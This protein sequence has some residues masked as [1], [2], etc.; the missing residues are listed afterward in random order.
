M[1][2]AEILDVE[3]LL[4]L[5]PVDLLGAADDGDEV[6]DPERATRYFP[7]P[8]TLFDDSMTLFNSHDLQ[9]YMVPKRT[10]DSQK[11][12][13]KIFI[14]KKQNNQTHMYKNVKTKGGIEHQSVFRPGYLLVNN[15]IGSCQGTCE[16]M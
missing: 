12:L 8:P 5:F 7:N 16:S 10:P 1:R 14:E 11:D 13:A 2:F 3:T 15:A 9:V 4:R 6:S